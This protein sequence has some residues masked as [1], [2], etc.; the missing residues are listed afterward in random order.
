MSVLRVLAVRGRRL[1]SEIS[2]YSKSKTLL[3]LKGSVVA[4]SKED[5]QFTQN[6][7]HL[8][9]PIRTY[10]DPEKSCQPVASHCLA[11]FRV[12]TGASEDLSLSSQGALGDAECMVI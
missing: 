8:H 12:I 6:N 11:T 7:L 9:R 4:E 1:L 10:R 2:K 5:Y 3:D